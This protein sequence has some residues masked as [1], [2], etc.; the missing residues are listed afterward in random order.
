MKAKASS[1]GTAWATQSKSIRSK[2]KVSADFSPW[3]TRPEAVVARTL[4]PR[5]RDLTDLAMATVW[6]SEVAMAK[7]LKVPPPTIDSLRS[8][9]FCD[10]SQGAL[11]K[12][13][14]QGSVRCLIQGS[15]MYTY[16][17]DALFRA[18][19]HFRLQGMRDGLDFSQLTDADIRG[20][21]GEGL[22]LP[23]IGVIIWALFLE[24]RA[25]WWH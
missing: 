22:C 18:E 23:C 14:S 21:A 8:N 13:W 3:T 5:Y 9:L 24:S 19:H 25:A 6:K 2:L 7:K 1:K 12:P 11:R 4:H 20:L 15:L 16:E 10:L 17:A